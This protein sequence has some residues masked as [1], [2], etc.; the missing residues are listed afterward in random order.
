MPASTA[1]S[2]RELRAQRGDLSIY[3]QLYLP[4]SWDGSPLP[5]VVCAHGF[6]ANYLH[7]VPYAWTLAEAGF[8]VYCF[9]FC[10]GGYAS[11]S[12]GNP[13]NMSLDSELA[14]FECVVGMVR[15]QDF[16]DESCLVC[17]GEDLGGLVA[18]MVADAMPEEVS[19]LVLLY[20]TLQLHDETRRTFPTKKN[21]PHSYRLYG[22]RVGRAFGEAA[23]DAN[24]YTHMRDFG[25]DVLIVHGDEDATNLVEYSER[26]A[27][28]FRSATL[29]TIHGGKHVFRDQA[30]ERAQGL[31][32]RFV[33]EQASKAAERR[34]EEARRRALADAATQA[35]QDA[36]RAAQQALAEEF[37]ADPVAPGQ[38]TLGDAAPAQG[39]EPLAGGRDAQ[40]AAGAGTEGAKADPTGGSAGQAASSAAGQ[41]AGEKGPAAEAGRHAGTAGARPAGAP[42]RSR[43]VQPDPSKLGRRRARHFRDD[44]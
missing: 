42:K 25:G 16:C 13:I 44:D 23:W 4:G 37:P 35:T 3:G 8:A 38:L 5:T 39:A 15:A 21:I 26:A 31:V 24:P 33:R 36:I 11:R 20:P 12:D 27:E 7:N 22:M 18:T 34:R 29:E 41:A 43:Y 32:L 17:M 6:G 40:A 30:L 1:Y 19:A 9:D 14:D 10:G 28:V 2:N